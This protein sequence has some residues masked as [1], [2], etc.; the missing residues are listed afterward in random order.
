MVMMMA[1]VM[2]MVVVVMM[3]MAVVVVVI[4]VMMICSDNKKL[5][6]AVQT[7]LRPST[8]PIYITLLLHPSAHTKKLQNC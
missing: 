2:M 5:R 3:M 6:N 1:V 4:V 7:N 8:V